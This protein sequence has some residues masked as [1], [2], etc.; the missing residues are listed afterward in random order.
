[1]DDISVVKHHMMLTSFAER[2]IHADR[3]I[4]PPWWVY[5]GI[6]ERNALEIISFYIIEGYLKRIWVIS[7]V[8]KYVIRRVIRKITRKGGKGETLVSP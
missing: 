7:L 4:V 8:R 5:L 1:M 3:P 2:S 6:M